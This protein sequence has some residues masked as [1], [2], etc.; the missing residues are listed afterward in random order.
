[1]LSL[2]A[3]Y[4]AVQLGPKRVVSRG[5]SFSISFSGRSIVAA[6]LSKLLADDATFGLR[7]ATDVLLSGC[8]AGGL[9]ALL[10]AERLHL[11]AR[12]GQLL[13]AEVH[14][15]K[16]ADDRPDRLSAGDLRGRAQAGDSQSQTAKGIAVH[17]ARFQ[18]ETPVGR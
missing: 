16:P 4:G 10:H 12:P 2:R 8:S 14:E 5:E 18:I 17:T 11:L 7:R 9:A 15:V 3:A 13:L 6:I 1:M